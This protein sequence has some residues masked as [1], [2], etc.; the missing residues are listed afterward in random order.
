VRRHCGLDGKGEEAGY[1][2]VREHLLKNCRRCC[3]G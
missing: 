3:S 1:E 2:D